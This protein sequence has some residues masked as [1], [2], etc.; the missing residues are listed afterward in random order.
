MAGRN[1]TPDAL[2]R[3]RGTDQRCR[4]SG[5]DSMT[6]AL[7]SLSEAKPPAWLT[8]VGKKIYREKAQQLISI[9]VLTELDLGLLA[10]YANSYSLAVDAIV[11]IGK[12]GKAATVKNDEGQVVSFLLNPYLKIYTDNIKIINTIGSQF[13]FS[14]S[15]RASIMALAAKRE[16]PADDFDEFE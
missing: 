12:Q 1:K 14:P 9:G 7:S 10:M 2:K 8:T 6:D 3:L 16:G 4:L 11:Q 5:D 13:G 15:S